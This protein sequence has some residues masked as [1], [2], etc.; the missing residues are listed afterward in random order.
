MIK[1]NSMFLN[2]DYLET[3][4]TRPTLNKTRILYHGSPYDLD[5]IEP[6]CLNAGTRI[7]NPRYSSFWTEHETNCL[8][9]ALMGLIDKYI[10]PTGP[11]CLVAITLDFQKLIINNVYKDQVFKLLSKHPVFVYKAEIPNKLIA[12]GHN[13][14]DNEFTLD[15]PVKISP[16]NKKIFYYND[17]KDYIEYRTDK[18][19]FTFSYIQNKK[20]QTDQSSLIE[21]LIYHSS[22]SVRKRKREINKYK[23][24]EY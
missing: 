18:Q 12:R 7:S 13:R 23:K 1:Q 10:K 9:W 6:N 17:F 19:I 15:F 20:S 24:G 11:D 3:Y 8:I 16:N 4:I 21:K 2:E 22:D 14:E 5:V